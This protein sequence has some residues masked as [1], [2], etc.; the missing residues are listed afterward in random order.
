MWSA[1]PF[2]A[3]DATGGK[4][5]ELSY[6]VAGIVPAFFLSHL[7]REK[8]EVAAAHTAKGLNRPAPGGRL[9]CLPYQH[10]TAADRTDGVKALTAALR[11]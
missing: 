9:T 7:D 6:K 5:A 11:S 1:V 8:R 4:L 3:D 10:S 2:Q